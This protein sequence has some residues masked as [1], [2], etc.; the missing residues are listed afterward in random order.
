MLLKYITRLIIILQYLF[1]ENFIIML[2]AIMHW[3]QTLCY[4]TISS[5]KFSSTAF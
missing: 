5:S 4:M 3:A 1:I 2:Y